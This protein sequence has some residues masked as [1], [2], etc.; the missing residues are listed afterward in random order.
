MH[1]FLPANIMKFVLDT[2]KD[3]LFTL[4]HLFN[5]DNSSLTSL[6]NSSKLRLDLNKLVASANKICLRSFETL[7]ISFIYSINKRG[8]RTEPCGTPHKTSKSLEDSLSISTYCFLFNKQ[9]HKNLF[10]MP[11]IP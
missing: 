11:R 2:F 10:T 3:N 5:L 9:L 1:F 6:H 8:P 7:H 4:N